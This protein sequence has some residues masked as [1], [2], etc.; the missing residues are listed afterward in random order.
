MKVWKKPEDMKIFK[1]G[2]CVVTYFSLKTYKENT[3]RMS[4]SI[5]LKTFGYI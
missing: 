3:L 5:L 4:I 2:Y 1:I